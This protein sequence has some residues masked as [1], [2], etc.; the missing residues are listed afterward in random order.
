VS[1][2]LG[3]QVLVGRVAEAVGEEHEDVR[4][5]N[6]RRVV[7]SAGSGARRQPRSDSP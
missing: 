5:P 1:G 6:L 7:R 3:E 4:V 2:E